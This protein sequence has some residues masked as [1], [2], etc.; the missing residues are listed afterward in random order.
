MRTETEML[1]V[2]LKTAETLQVAAVAMSGSRTDTK[3][4]KD[5]FQDYDVVYVVDDLDNLTSDL[6]WLDQFGK[7]IIEQEVGLGQRRLYLMLF[8]DGNRIDLTLCPK[9]H[10]KEWVDSESKF[11]VLEDEKGLFAPYSPTPQRYWTSPASETDFENSCNEF[12]WVSAYV[13][14]GICRNQVIY[15]TDH[16]Y[17]ICQQE[18]LKI[19]AWQVAS[20]RGKVDIGKNYKYLFNYL[21]AEKKK[22]FSNLLDFSSLD[23]ITQSLFATMQLFHREAQR[24]AQKLGFDYDKEVAEKMIQYAE[25]RLEKNETFTK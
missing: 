16:L 8:E 25:E 22:E 2:I 10:M 13:G 20:D 18:F 11:I 12:W 4:P 9:E 19:L 24:L 21:P 5:E 7:R 1:D 14:K 23:K 3:A 6:S 15:A 17:G